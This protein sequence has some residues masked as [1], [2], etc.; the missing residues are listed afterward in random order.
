MSDVVAFNAAAGKIIES[1]FRDYPY[2]PR[3]FKP[4]FVT[5]DIIRFWKTLC[6]NYEN[7]RNILG[8]DQIID[9]LKRRKQQIKNYKLKFSRLLTCFATIGNLSTF[10]ESVEPADVAT[11]C[12]L[13]PIDRL[14]QI[15]DK[16]RKARTAVN[17]AIA[18]YSGFLTTTARSPDDLVKYSRRR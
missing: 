16:R 14:A 5:N 9:H 1:Y 15:A 12:S 2:H 6:L 3:D 17:D 8:P 4:T 11:L 10:D 13:A 7:R 18:L